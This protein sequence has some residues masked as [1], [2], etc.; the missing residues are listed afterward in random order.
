MVTGKSAFL[1]VR[2]GKPQGEDLPPIRPQI[3]LHRLIIDTLG[4]LLVRF[5]R[6]WPKLKVS[7]PIGRSQ[8]IDPK[9]QQAH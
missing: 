1:I 5:R 2:A 3:V 8:A 4:R 6:P 7:A 9:R